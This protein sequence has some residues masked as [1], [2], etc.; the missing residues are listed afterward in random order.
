[1]RPLN[2]PNRTAAYLSGVH[3][4][5]LP[6]PEEL[7]VLA[8]PLLDATVRIGELLRDLPIK[9]AMGGEI[10]EILMGVNVRPDHLTILTS[11]DGCNQISAKLATAEEG[12]AQSIERKLDRDAEIDLKQYPV[13]VKSYMARFNVNG[14]RLDVYGDLQIKVGD[15]DWGDP[16]DYEPDYV[17]VVSEKVPVLPLRL[18]LN[19]YM[20]LGW[21]DRVRKINEAEAKRHHRL[22]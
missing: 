3:Q 15:W 10:G 14:Q 7:I 6:K 20:G 8:K 11:A 16:L 12:S 22:G 1:M 4:D 21:I 18:K 5:R 2:V 17:Y 19:L 13:Y 9:W